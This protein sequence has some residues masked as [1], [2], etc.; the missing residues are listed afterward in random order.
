MI[1]F[2]KRTAGTKDPKKSRADMAEKIS[3]TVH[4]RSTGHSWCTSDNSA[5]GGRSVIE[6]TRCIGCNDSIIEKSRHGEYF[7]GL[8][9]QQIELRQIDDIGEAGKQRVERDIERCE[10]VLKELDLWDEVKEVAV[11]NG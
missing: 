10:Q 2:I 6:A 1:Q 4:L 7:K 3:S 9:L 11:P 5:C 8:Y